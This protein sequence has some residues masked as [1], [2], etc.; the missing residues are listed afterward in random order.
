MVRQGREAIVQNT[1]IAWARRQMQRMVR[2]QV[3]EALSDA[4]IGSGTPGSL[5]SVPDSPSLNFGTPTS[6]LSELEAGQAGSAIGEMSDVTL[7]LEPI[8][9]V[10]EQLGSR[11]L[12]GGCST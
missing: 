1:Y 3:E 5:P 4:G 11:D 12:E 2:Q 9:E 10:V 8:Q 7:D 6:C